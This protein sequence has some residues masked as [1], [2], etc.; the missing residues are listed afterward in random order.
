MGNRDAST[1]EFWGGSKDIQSDDP[2]PAAQSVDTTMVPWSGGSM[3]LSDL[4]F[5]AARGTPTV[6]GVIGAHDAGK[7]TFLAALFLL[8]LRHGNTKKNTFAGSC[9]L[10]G[11]EQLASHLRWSG[12]E[13]PRFPPH[14]AAF[15]RRSPGLLHLAFRTDSGVL[16]DLL[17]VDA[18]G[19][20]FRQWA[21]DR[22]AS[23][24]EG[25][26]WVAAH[27]DLFLVFADC[28]ALAGDNRGESRVITRQILQRVV[29]ERRNRPL[30]LIWSKCDVE[31]AP[32]MRESV[33][34]LLQGIT[35]LSEVALS[36][37]PL[38]PKDEV[39]EHRFLDLLDGVLSLPMSRDADVT[40]PTTTTRDFFLEFR[41]EGNV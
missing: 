16:R 6:V 19:E 5:V 26:R 15:E 24:A 34:E 36:V 27:S 3:G 12:S 1:C 23:G 28:A 30:M 14:T 20:W 41:G 32:H 11:W 17:F 31:I 9:S 13:P 40:L 39:A 21:F 37:K 35:P 8:M 7:T 2:P 10:L 25:A 18:P 22:D 38:P 33:Q 29:T 4:A